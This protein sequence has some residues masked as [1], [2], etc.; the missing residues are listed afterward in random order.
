VLSA[1]QFLKRGAVFCSLRSEC[2]ELYESDNYRNKTK[3]KVMWSCQPDKNTHHSFILILNKY[4]LSASR[5]SIRQLYFSSLLYV[6]QLVFIPLLFLWNISFLGN[7]PFALNSET[8]NR[9]DSCQDSLAGLSA[10]HKAATYTEQ[11]IQ[12]TPQ[13]YIYG[14]KGI[15]TYDLSL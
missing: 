15:W 2:F 10:R 7:L 13:T 14:S 11:H 3:P 1:L 4:L 6:M 8:K 9:I 12:K 5:E